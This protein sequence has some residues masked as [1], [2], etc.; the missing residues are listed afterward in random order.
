MYKKQTFF[1]ANCFIP[2]DIGDCRQDL[3]APTYYRDDL[4]LRRQVL[5]DDDV[6]DHL[7]EEHGGGERRLLLALGRQVEAE[8]GEDGHEHARTDEVYHVE[9]ALSL[10]LGRERDG[11][12]HVRS[13]VRV[14]DVDGDVCEVPLTVTRILGEVASLRDVREGEVT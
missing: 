9:G 13:E 4:G 8:G 11:R 6:E 2:T 12:V 1:G 5:H 3:L 7:R 14:F 10:D